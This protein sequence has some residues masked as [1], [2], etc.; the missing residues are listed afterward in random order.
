MQKSFKYLYWKC[1]HCGFKLQ[2]KKESILLPFCLR[3]ALIC[4]NS[5]FPV[6]GDVRLG[7]TSD[8]R[9][10]DYSCCNPCFHPHRVSR[11]SRSDWWDIDDAGQSGHIK[12]CELVYGL[13]I[14][15]KLCVLADC[16]NKP[17]DQ[18]PK[19]RNNYMVCE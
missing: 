13:L 4:F 14:T 19:E 12:L 2:R 5:I 16:N 6:S 18:S 11:F 1:V 15:Q 17:T 10:K 7:V 3:C 8:K 9:V